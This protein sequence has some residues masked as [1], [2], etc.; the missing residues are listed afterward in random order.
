[1]SW[2]SREPSPSP[3]FWRPTAAAASAIT[4][5]ALPGFLLGAFAP[6]IKEELNFG[7]TELGALLT[8]GYLVSS[9]T[10]QVGG[11]IADR[12]GPLLILRVGITIAA[13][14]ALLTGSTADTYLT[15]L[16]CLGLN[17]VA[18]GMI[19]PAT[20][21]LISIG[22]EPSR[23]GIAMAIKQ[24]AIPLS[25]ALAGF[26]VPTLGPALG[27]K[28]TFLILAIFAFPAWILVPRVAVSTSETFPTRREMWSSRHLQAIGLAGAFSAAAVVTVSGFL[29]TAAKEA[30]YSDSGAGLILGLG[31]LIMILSRLAWGYLADRFQFD[32]FR[33]VAISLALGSVA[34]IL[35]AVG[36]KITILVGALFIFGIGWSWPGLLLLGVIEQ[37]PEEPGAA[38][39]TLQTSIRLGAMI[40]P[41]GFG[42]L[43]D[44][45][46]FSVAWL[47]AFSSTI[48]GSLLMFAASRTIGRR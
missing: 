16:L 30:G 34:F 45:F 35:F 37:H 46:G 33:A 26:A 3:L 25:T 38:T 9:M 6:Q 15:L 14:S 44:A 29:T 18:E 48:L 40:A 8:F 47:T 21:T 32:R 22:V 13:I 7:D 36:T 31:G 11:G 41:I 39:A 27:W 4:L 5:V 43:T 10:M 12:K 2:N 20:N 42:A 28:G 23:Q 17:R 19:H 24:S 1:M